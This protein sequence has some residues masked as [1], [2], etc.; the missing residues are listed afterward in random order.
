VYERLHVRGCITVVGRALQDRVMP[1]LLGWGLIGLV[2]ALAQLLLLFLCLLFA[3]HLRSG[4]AP[5][6]HREP[7]HRPGK[8]ELQPLHYTS[9]ARGHYTSTLSVTLR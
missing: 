7:G 4:L 1:L 9:L 6:G 2:V 8:A 3:Q 5:S